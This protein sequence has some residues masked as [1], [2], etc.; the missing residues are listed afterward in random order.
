MPREFCKFNQVYKLF[1]RD[2]VSDLIVNGGV[3]LS[4]TEPWFCGRTEYHYWLNNWEKFV[5]ISIGD[6]NPSLY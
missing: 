2:P 6:I 1:L 4:L 3:S 5:M